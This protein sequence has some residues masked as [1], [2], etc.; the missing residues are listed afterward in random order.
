MERL[1]HLYQ[2]A[3]LCALLASLLVALVNLFCFEKLK[4]ARAAPESP[5]VSILVPARNEARNIARCVRSLLSQDYPY[6]EIIVLD[7]QSEDD[8]LSIA[9]G[10]GLSETGS[11]RRLIRGK[12]LPAGWT[13]KAWA[14]HQLARGARGAFLFFTDADTEHAPGTV[15]A[16]VACAEGRRADLVSAWPRLETVSWSERLI[17]PMLVTLAMILYGHFVLTALQAQPRFAKLIPK[18]FLRML[19]AANG[20]CLF[21]RRTAYDAIGGHAAVRGH[22]V[23]DMAL[24]RLIAAGLGSGSR[25]FNCD[26]QN[27]STCRMYRSLGEVWEGFTKNIRAAFEDSLGSYLAVGA[28]QLLCFLLPFALLVFSRHDRGLIAAQIAV[29][30]LIR[31]IVTIRFATAWESCAFHPAAHALC[32]AIGLNSWRK[33]S[34]GGVTWKGR[35]YSTSVGMD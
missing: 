14:C 27:F 32:L 17:V 3:I 29:I 24:G 19:G 9:T 26:G 15:S 8:T 34:A 31:T 30:Y 2:I 20:Q 23:E 6:C 18:R 25:L 33:M 16:L 7:D 13:G 4:G 21:F 28:S 5:L 11:I 10:L 22:L 12:A 35:I 1:A